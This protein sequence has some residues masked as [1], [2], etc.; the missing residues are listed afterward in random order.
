MWGMFI[1]LVLSK[2]VMY[3]NDI[4][5]MNKQLS[6][7][8]IRRPHLIRRSLNLSASVRVAI[9]AGLVFIGGL[10]IVQQV[11]A[12]Q[13]S[14]SYCS[15]YTENSK[16]NACKDGIKG[17][18]CADYA[19]TFDQEHA[20]IC[21]KAAK[22]KASNDISDTPTVSVS[23]SPS[24]SSST[25][26]SS[27][28]PTVYKNVVLAACGTY[29]SSTPAYNACL[30]G[31]SA[32]A[33]STAATPKTNQDCLTNAD[34][35][36]STTNQAACVAGSTAGQKYVA[37]QTNSAASGTSSNPFSFLDQLNQSN[38]LSQYVDTLHANGQDKGVDVSQQAD[39]NPGSYV[40]GAGK[41]QPIKVTPCAGGSTGSGIV[42]SATNVN[43]FAEVTTKAAGKTCPA[44]IFFNGGGWHAN[45]HTSDYVATGSSD[46]NGDSNQGSIGP[47]AG[48]GATQRGFTVIDVTYRLGS[49]S[50][51]YAFEDVMRGLQHV[52]NNADIYN[53]DSNKIAIFGDSAGGSL[54]MRAA[55]SGKSGAKVAVGWS[56]PTNAY[57]GLFRSYKSL[58]IGMD[59][60]TCAPTDLAGLTNITDLLNG[61]SGDVAQYGQGLSSND[62]SSLGIG[63][64]DSPLPSGAGGNI[65]A[66]GLITEVL[67]AGQYAMKTGQNAE[68]I[69]KQL[70]SGGGGLPS[71][72]MNLSSK[73]F[74]EC[75]DNFN[76]LSPALF[77]SP[78]TPPSFVA[79][80][81]NDD[82]VGPEQ[83]YGMRDK[84]LSLGIRSEALVLPGDPT[85]GNQAL[86]A[87]GNHLGYNPLFVCKT[88]NFI[89]SVMNP[90]KGQVNCE[91]GVS[92]NQGS[93]DAVASGGSGTGGGGTAAQNGS[94]NNTTSQGGQSNCESNDGTWKLTSKGGGYCAYNP[95]SA[96]C[97]NASTALG[98]N[99]VT[100]TGCT[101]TGQASSGANSVSRTPTCPSGGSYSAANGGCI[102][103]VNGSTYEDASQSAAR[104]GSARYVQKV[105]GS[106]FYNDPVVTCAYGPTYRNR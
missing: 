62:F 18:D 90:D 26:P 49:S 74:T 22:A 39:N 40:N 54:S 9:L 27:I 69:S 89:D 28:N 71:N 95:N 55:A 29:K 52:I 5:I 31:G 43:G 103:Q 68:S 63:Q 13:T 87:S 2:P 102:Y 3:P 76:A 19:I 60:S 33:G 79:G 8:K 73:K 93:N 37:D 53:I 15:Q 25:L 11:E 12:A 41:Q 51:Y 56:P 21:T 50:V 96:T 97:R 70:E 47:P 58:M 75:L 86:G 10:G 92:S 82:V 44:I 48:G 65:D 106:A 85:A 100:P 57:T 30:F 88:L 77:A 80:F 98:V 24:P 6:R 104:C 1:P 38:N 78:E 45:D 59:H 20:D 91:T 64:T 35:K 32:Q 23:V 101:N 17:S 36:N 46:R 84:L 99:Q 7:L 83:V 14:A 67:T 72:I 66:L 94:P 16:L 4:H 34:F 61:G 42:K 105:D 81:E